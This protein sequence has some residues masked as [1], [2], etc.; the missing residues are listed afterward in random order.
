MV[1]LMGFWD[2][3]RRSGATLGVRGE[4]H[5]ARWLRKRGYR[6]LERN[7]KAGGEEA[8]LVMLAPDGATLVIVEVKTRRRD[9]PP[10][11]ANITPAKQ[12]HLS[13]VASRLSRSPRYRDRPV[14]ID[15]I[16]IVWPEGGA[17]DVTHYE[18]AFEGAF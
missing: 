16:T 8:D 7:R 17:P 15:V 18:N 1:A 3:F 4:R 6:L 13:R 9:Q 5:A 14:R 2:V 12:R 11:E 10:P